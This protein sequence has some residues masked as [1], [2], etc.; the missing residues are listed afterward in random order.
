V[1]IYAMPQLLDEIL[2]SVFADD[3]RV[4]LLRVPSDVDSVVD[5][6]T[7]TEPDV[8]IVEEQ[9]AGPR[10]VD[11]LLRLVP[12]AQALTIAEDA[13]TALLYELQPHRRLIGELSPTSIRAAVYHARR[14]SDL[15]FEP[16]PAP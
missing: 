9:H 4:T 8:V 3:A 5:A 15:L 1:L 13:S 14:R 16:R 7:L 12:H 6:V 10:E 11:N 2:D